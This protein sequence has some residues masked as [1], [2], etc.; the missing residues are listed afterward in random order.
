MTTSAPEIR[1]VVVGV[2]GSQTSEYAAEYAIERAK[3]EHVAITLLHARPLS[4]ATA[5]ERTDLGDIESLAERLRERG[6]DLSLDV[7]RSSPSAALIEVSAPDTLVV[8]GT[9]GHSGLP[10]LLTGSV[11]SAVTGAGDGPVVVVTKAPPAQ[12]PVTLGID[13]DDPA[14]QALSR[15]AAEARRTGAPLQVIHVWQVEG[16]R[17]PLPLEA[18]QA[19]RQRRLEALLARNQ[20]ET[21]GIDVTARAAQ[22]D[23]DDV[24]L[25]AAHTSSLL[26][27][28]SRGRGALAGALL[29]SVSRT[30]AAK[31][32]CPVMVVRG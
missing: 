10:G 15:A 12:G 30:C 18:E 14:P 2:D 24:L 13:L 5:V 26:V 19:E 16:A 4:M 11:A 22:G 1:H 25:R 31:A 8:I 32:D 29:G 3:E 23:P 20:A 27:L 21:E 7:V 28:G 6:A 9:R 17:G